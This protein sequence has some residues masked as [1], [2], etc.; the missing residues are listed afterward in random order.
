MIIACATCSPISVDLDGA[1]RTL[2]G[3][4]VPVSLTESTE[5]SSLTTE[6][7]G[8][9]NEIE[10]TTACRMSATSTTSPWSLTHSN[11]SAAASGVALNT[12]HDG[13][14]RVGARIASNNGLAK[15]TLSVY[16]GFLIGVSAVALGASVGAL[17][18]TL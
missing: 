14:Y 10:H 7:L 5:T 16:T 17:L 8:T 4:V 11:S 1:S 18:V 3:S 6:V 15:N 13:V 12:R 2:D 9:L